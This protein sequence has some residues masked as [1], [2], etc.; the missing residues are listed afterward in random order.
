MTGDRGLCSRT[1]TVQFD[2][3]SFVWR[4]ICHV[5]IDHTPCARIQC[6]VN[7]SGTDIGNKLKCH[8]LIPRW[9]GG[10]EQDKISAKSTFLD[11]C[12]K[13]EAFGSGV[14]E[15][16]GSLFVQDIPENGTNRNNLG[17]PLLSDQ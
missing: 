11:P 2:D 6:S 12:Y 5:V 7:N 14:L 10:Y 17:P 3:S 16:L 15:E 4:K 8:L 1:E 13:M 9:L